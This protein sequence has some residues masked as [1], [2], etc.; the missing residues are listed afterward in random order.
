M[1]FKKLKF[2]FNPAG[3][4]NAP[5]ADSFKNG[6]QARCHKNQSQPP[7]VIARDDDA[8]DKAERADD[9]ARH[10]A[11]AVQIGAKKIAHAKMLACRAP[12]AKGL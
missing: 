10:S 8:R 12:K 4:N 5:F 7:I 2:R 3:A 9:A 1:N 11:V 6:E